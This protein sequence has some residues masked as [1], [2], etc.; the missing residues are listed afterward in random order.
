MGGHKTL[1]QTNKQCLGELNVLEDAKNFFYFRLPI[2]LPS[3]ST[4]IGGMDIDLG[5]ISTM[6]MDI[7]INTIF[8]LVDQNE[9]LQ[10]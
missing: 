9:P 6:V 3:I 2:G 4:E 10:F 8:Q 7:D 5:D 1:E